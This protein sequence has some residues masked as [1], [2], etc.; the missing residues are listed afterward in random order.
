MTTFNQADWEAHQTKILGL[1]DDELIKLRAKLKKHD[2]LVDKML[3]DEIKKWE[4]RKATVR[5]AEPGD[6]YDRWGN[7]NPLKNNKHRADMAQLADQQPTEVFGL[8]KTGSAIFLGGLALVAIPF[9]GLFVWGGIS[10]MMRGSGI[11]NGMAST[12]ACERAFRP[13]LKDPGSYQYISSWHTKETTTVKFRAKNS[14]GGY[15]EESRTCK[16]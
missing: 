3:L 2:G 4:K 1:I 13:T 14:F 15:A 12:R 9:M 10:D 16:K 7:L 6:Y 8:G 11:D 5:Q